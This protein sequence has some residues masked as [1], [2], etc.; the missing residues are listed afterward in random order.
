MDSKH[1]FN[2]L[3]KDHTYVHSRVGAFVMDVNQ[4]QLQL[5]A[6]TD[7]WSFPTQEYQYLRLP[8]ATAKT[9]T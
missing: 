8:L 9:P 7:L 2:L 1:S 6:T 3:L 4:P 5:I